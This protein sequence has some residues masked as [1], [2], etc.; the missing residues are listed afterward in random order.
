[1]DPHATTSRNPGI[2]GAPLCLGT[3]AVTDGI[4]RIPLERMCGQSRIIHLSPI[5]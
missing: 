4:V 5:A 1:M 3:L 2:G